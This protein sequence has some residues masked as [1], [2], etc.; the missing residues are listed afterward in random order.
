MKTWSEV[1]K[2]KSLSLIVEATTYCNA[3]CPQCKR[4]NK[5]GLQKEDFFDLNSWSL[6][7]FMTYFNEE[8]LNH[9]K[10]IHFSGTYGDPGMCKDIF[11]IVDYIF[12]T[13]PTTKVSLNT[14]G[15]MRDEDWWYELGSLSPN[16][17]LV[18]FDVD[19]VNQEMHEKYRRGTNL[20]KVLNNMQAYALS[21]AKVKTLTIIFKHNQDYYDEIK[22]MVKNYGC[23]NPVA[24]ESNR[25]KTAPTWKFI[26]ENGE[27]EI[28]EQ[29]TDPRFKRDPSSLNRRNRDWKLGNITETYDY[30]VCAKAAA[31][32]LHILNTGHVYPCCYLGTVDASKIQLEQHKTNPI[33]NT[34]IGE[35]FN[36]KNR[37]L[38][39]IVNDE[40]YTH[41]LFKS[42]NN[43]ST[44]MPKCKSCCGY[45]NDENLNIIETVQVC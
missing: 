44:A 11:E 14:N 6:K 21:G 10:N 20:Q 16:K 9:I 19:G 42:L 34:L 43:K 25:F 39:Q 28:F 32:S 29:T 18:T 38:K 4:T 1:Y 15:S 30:I 40:W 7:D 17:L 12:K 33:W 5:N 37:S 36:L 23:F 31:G 22:K 27:E 35:D 8:D 26:N 45:R 3:K 41:L 2:N 13:S 24:I